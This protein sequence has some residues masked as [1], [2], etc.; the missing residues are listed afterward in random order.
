MLNKL[1]IFLTLLLTYSM[2]S[3]AFDH[4]HKAF[5]KILN[6]HVKL[7]G[8]Q[9][10]IDY[11]A[12]KKDISD[13]NSYLKLLSSVEK[14][15]YAAFSKDQQLAFLIN[16]YNAFTI[17]LIIDNYPLKSI[18]DIGSFF[19]STWKIKFFTLLEKK[20]NLDHVEHGIIGK[21]FNEPRIHFAV[22]CASI[23]CPSLYNQA[24]RATKLDAQLEQV[25][26]HFLSNQDKN[27]L[28]KKKNKV[29]LSKIFK[30]YGE[31]FEKK[32]GSVEK[33]VSKYLTSNKKI[34]A[35]I[36]DKK[37]PISWSDY[38]WKLNDI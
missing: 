31:D 3:S 12:V 4:T 7:K 8:K 6:T 15:E 37:Y 20:T 5:D 11:K 13:F 16:A 36:A 10:L 25:T 27:S 29:T 33:F 30:W 22:N 23:G 1:T 19:K 2:H 34:Q 24:F 28:N 35:E 17:K 26:I 18:K 14:K 32:F 9:S 21:K 38:D